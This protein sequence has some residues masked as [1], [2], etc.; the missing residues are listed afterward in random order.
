MRPNPAKYEA[1]NSFR[2]MNLTQ[3]HAIKRSFRHD[4][5]ALCLFGSSLISH[6]RPIALKGQ[7]PFLVSVFN[8]LW[9]IINV[10]PSYSAATFDNVKLCMREFACIFSNL[11]IGVCVCASSLAHANA[12][13]L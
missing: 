3:T 12:I 10:R 8:S 13:S 11:H 5:K 6:G 9:T 2:T 1:A 7:I 4:L